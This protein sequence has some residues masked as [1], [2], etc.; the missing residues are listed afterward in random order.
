L[1]KHTLNAFKEIVLVL[2]TFRKYRPFKII[3]RGRIMRLDS[4][5]FGNI[6]RMAKVLTLAPENR[7]DDGKFEV[8][9]FPSKRKLTLVKRLAK[10]AVSHIDSAK[11]LRKYSFTAVKKM[12][13]QLD[14]EVMVLH[15]LSK[16]V[17]E[18]A[19]KALP[20]IV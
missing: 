8:I 6:N 17:V 9:T 20:T 5:L 7:P 18:S 2:K 11:R 14:G 1:N 12:P 4:L 10:A 3:H 15:K 19:H 16:V 13:M